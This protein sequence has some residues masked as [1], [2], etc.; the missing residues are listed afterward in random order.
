MGKEECRIWKESYAV[1][2]E[3][4]DI[5]HKMLFQKVDELVQELEGANR[6]KVYQEIIQFL[7]AY[8]TFHFEDEEAYFKSIGYADQEK[9][10]KQH[11]DLKQ[12]VEK[13]AEQL[14][15][16]G[17][18]MHVVK[19]C[20]GMMSAWLVYHVVG[21]DLKY[22]TKAKPQ[23]VQHPSSYI[24]YFANST[25]EVL[26]TIAGLRTEDMHQTK[27]YDDLDMGDI[28]IEVAL[29]GDL[30]GSVVFGFTKDFSIQLVKTMLSFAPEEID[31]LVC[32]ALAEVSNISSGKGTI[33]ISEKGTACDIRPPQILQNGWRDLPAD[34]KMRI[35]TE[36]GTMTVAVY[37]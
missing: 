16:T 18:A 33:A 17:Y 23:S 35:D 7:K 15:N 29:I 8:V 14:E 6:P 12:E 10:I 2:I 31:D 30:Q 37:V 21:E 24:D 9:H 25:V 11:Q 4:I 32:S 1:G 27:I 22:T 13:Y 28:F 5:Q 3:N 20:A 36:I 26:E 34:Q 19:K